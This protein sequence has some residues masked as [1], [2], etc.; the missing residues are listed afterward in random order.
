MGDTSAFDSL[1]PSD[2]NGRDKIFAELM[3][4]DDNV[5]GNDVYRLMSLVDLAIH[6]S[7]AINDAPGCN[8]D[9]GITDRNIYDAHSA[10]IEAEVDKLL[11]AAVTVSKL[12]DED[13]LAKKLPW[14]SNIAQFDGVCAER[15]EDSGD[16]I[17]GAGG[18]HPSS[19]PKRVRAAVSLLTTIKRM[20][21]EQ[22]TRPRGPARREDHILAVVKAVA[23]YLTEQPNLVFQRSWPAGDPTEANKGLRGGILVPVEKL[24]PP[25]RTVELIKAVLD[26][27]GFECDLSRVRTRLKEYSTY[28][29][30]RQPEERDIWP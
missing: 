3:A 12:M 14:L 22:A 11:N 24:A 2:N 21:K 27:Y 8:E 23:I 18:C 15:F 6:F 26:A 30:G 16:D 1:G 4:L 9:L 17:A 5:R 20:D 25:T 7:I 19:V 13:E 10:Q 29:N 28:L